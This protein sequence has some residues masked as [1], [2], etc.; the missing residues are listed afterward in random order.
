MADTEL[1]SLVGLSSMEKV[2][3]LITTSGAKLL[4]GGPSS[5][6]PR[7]IERLEGKCVPWPIIVK[8]LRVPVRDASHIQIEKV[9]NVLCGPVVV[10]SLSR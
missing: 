6:K 3:N 9:P 5:Q 8:N 1:R 7:H 2:I 4:H 10:V